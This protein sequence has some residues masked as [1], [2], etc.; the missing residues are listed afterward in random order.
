M[1]RKGVLDVKLTGHAFD[2]PAAVKRGEERD[3]IEVTHEAFSLFKPNMVTTRNAKST[4]IA[5]L[6]GFKTLSA[7]D[8][9]QL[10]WRNSGYFDSL[11]C[12]F[13]VI[14]F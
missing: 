12:L 11:F 14:C 13:F 5:G 7:S 9:M 10:V 4:N 1:E 6:I 2:R 3:R 8:H